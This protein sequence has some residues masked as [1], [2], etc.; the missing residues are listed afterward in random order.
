MKISLPGNRRTWMLIAVLASL[1]VAFAYVA[2]RSGPLA[3][4]SVT[5]V[6]VEE[7]A[8]SPSLFGIGAVEARYTHRVGPTTAGR[9]RTLLVDVGDQVVAGQPLA[10]I[11]PI[12]LDERITAQQG[13]EGRAAALE[14]TAQAQLVM[15]LHCEAEEGEQRRRGLGIQRAALHDERRVGTAAHELVQLQQRLLH[16]DTSFRCARLCHERRCLNGS[17]LKLRSDARWLA[18]HHHLAQ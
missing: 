14:R 16:Y 7:R 2:L 12:D 10:E 1:G 3:P 8:I 6:T 17:D 11:D 9:V 13:A 15:V 5:L 18:L 4:V